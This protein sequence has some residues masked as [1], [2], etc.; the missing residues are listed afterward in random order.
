[1]QASLEGIHVMVDDPYGGGWLVVMLL[2]KPDELKGLLTP[3]QYI[4]LSS[5]VKTLE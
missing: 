1:M 5:K 3:Q 2:S 4:T